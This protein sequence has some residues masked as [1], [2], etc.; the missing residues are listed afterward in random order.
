MGRRGVVAAVVLLLAGAAVAGVSAGPRPP[1]P[2]GRQTIEIG[3]SGDEYAEVYGGER[4]LVVT[5]PTATEF[6]LADSVT[7]QVRVVGNEPGIFGARWMSDGAH[8]VGSGHVCAAGASCDD[9]P[10][11]VAD[12]DLATGRW[13]TVD[14]GAIGVTRDVDPDSAVLRPLGAAD[15][16]FYFE[17]VTSSAASSR[18]LW[19]LEDGAVEPVEGPSSWFAFCPTSTGWLAVTERAQ[20]TAPQR[21]GPTLR[22]LGLVT[23]GAGIAPATTPLDDAAG[24]GPARLLCDGDGV[25][26]WLEDGIAHLDTAAARWQVVPVDPDR[27]EP[28]EWLPIAAN[29]SVVYTAGGIELGADEVTVGTVAVV[30]D[31]GG[32]WRTVADTRVTRPVTPTRIPDAED[33]DVVGNGAGAYV[34]LRRVGGLTLS[35]VN[36]G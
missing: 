21:S 19:V 2:G 24:A 9:G 8:L 22:D 29:G 17:V 1:A 33:L 4:W 15:G 18:S 20:A 28:N 25:T 35:P 23:G 34:I 10:A 27:P 11:T 13:R 16:R 26:A 3:W 32:Q 30:V 14:I 5:S 31:P 6:Q 7:G 12:Y 36:T